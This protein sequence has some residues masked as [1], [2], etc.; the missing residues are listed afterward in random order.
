ME[1]V[2]LIKLCLVSNVT[3]RLENS[4]SNRW[5]RGLLCATIFI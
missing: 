4:Y 5:K 3:L 1:K 2:L